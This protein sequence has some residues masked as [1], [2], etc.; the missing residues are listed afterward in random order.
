MNR[1]LNHEGQERKPG[2]VVGRALRVEKVKI[3][4]CKR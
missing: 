2:H 3:K 4:K 1:N